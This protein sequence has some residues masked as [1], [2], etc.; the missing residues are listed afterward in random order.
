MAPSSVPWHQ[1]LEALA[2]DLELDRIMRR[3]GL[4]REDMAQILRFAASLLRMENTS[5]WVLYV[6]GA[7]R[8]NPGP[9]GAGAVL[10]GPNGAKQAEESRYLGEATNNMAEYQALLLGLDLARNQGAKHLKVFSDSE[11]LVR[12]LKGIYQVRKAHLY[13][14]WHQ[15]QEKLQQFD[16]VEIYHVDR[17]LNFEAD[18]LARKAI[19]RQRRK[20]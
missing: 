11:L 20:R 16:S 10:Y 1:I 19:D 6:D 4:S 13:P 9:A 2:E 3:F 8:G 12:Q 17:S 14:L 5:S 15:A 7:S 18:Q